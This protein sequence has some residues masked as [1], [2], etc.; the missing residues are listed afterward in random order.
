LCPRRLFLRFWADIQGEKSKS[1]LVQSR[2]PT[3]PVVA[4]LTKQVRRIPRD[5]PHLF[6]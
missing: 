6:C 5:T 4:F 3:Q 1:F 2:P